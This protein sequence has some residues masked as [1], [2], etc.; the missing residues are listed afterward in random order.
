DGAPCV[1]LRVAPQED[2]RDENSDCRRESHTLMMG[3]ER[4]EEIDKFAAGRAPFERHICVGERRKPVEDERRC[5]GEKDHPGS[6][7]SPAERRR[8]PPPGD[9]VRRNEQHEEQTPEQVTEEDRGRRDR[10][11]NRRQERS[12]IGEPNPERGGKESKTDSVEEVDEAEQEDT[13]EGDDR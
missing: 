5:Q 1:E 11:H 4:R 13:V 7:R 2:E 8:L 3:E 12:T 10:R 9:F 6:P